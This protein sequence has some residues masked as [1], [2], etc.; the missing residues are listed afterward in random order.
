MTTSGAIHTERPRGHRRTSDDHASSAAA[1]DHAKKSSLAVEAAAGF[2]ETP[3]VKAIAERA[4]VY[5]DAGYP[6]HLAGPAGTGKTTLA[7]HIAAG[8]G[9]PVSL[10]HGNESFN[11][12]DLLGRDAGYKRST[13]VDN[14]I[15]SVLK[16]E[17]SVDVNW[18]DNRLTTAC[19]RGHT[20]VYDEFN[21]TRAEANNILLGLL[22]EG[23]LSTPRSGCGYIRVHPEFRMILT[24][25]P[26]EYAGVHRAQDALLDRLITIRCDHYDAATET[27][28]VAAASGLDG[29]S[30]GVIVAM[31]RALRGDDGTADQ[32]TVRAAI[33]LGCVCAAGAVPID[34]SEPRFV[35]MA[36]DVLGEA[37][38]QIGASGHRLSMNEFDELLACVSSEQSSGAGGNG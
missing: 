17:E 20:L 9:R 24:S 33:A 12:T 28:I 26:S 8:R 27:D 37:A 32:P 31:V 6:V 16:T 14:F 3:E 34:R 4:A 21:R 11:G 23:I 1:A 29:A 30:A 5:L 13:T 15:H 2:I 7:F 36:Y 25:N 18:I 38:M 19:E 22:E 35:A 10:L